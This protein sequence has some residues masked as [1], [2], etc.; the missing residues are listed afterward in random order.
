MLFFDDVFKTTFINYLPRIYYD[1][2]QKIKINLL[3]PFPPMEAKNCQILDRLTNCKPIIEAKGKRPQTRKKVSSQLSNDNELASTC[4][5]DYRKLR[6]LLMGQK[7][8]EADK[9][10]Y[11]VML[12]AVDRKEDEWIRKD[13]ILEFPCIDLRTIDGL[14]FRYSGGHFGFS[15]QK[16]IYEKVGGVLDGKF[17]KETWER[18]SSSVGWRVDQTWIA[19]KE[20]TSDTIVQD[21]YFPRGYFVFNQLNPLEGWKSLILIAVAATSFN[22]TKT[23]FNF[24]NIFSRIQACKL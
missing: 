7:W 5:I 8:N 12:L 3:I 10:T 6:D 9:E 24:L 18:F 2:Y 11:S 14:W 4:N 20:V 13:E 16:R 19:Y 22:S 21:G 23:W 1:V 17:N 15:V